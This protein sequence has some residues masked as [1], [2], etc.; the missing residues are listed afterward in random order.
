MYIASKL[1]H[2]TGIGVMEVRVSSD[3]DLLNQE[4]SAV[5]CRRLLYSTSADERE[6]VTCFLDFQEMR[7]LP[8]KMT[9]PLTDL[10]VR[11]QNA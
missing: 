11:E 7:V 1:S 8:R 9:K 10:R 6:T 4:S 3:S 2:L 5:R